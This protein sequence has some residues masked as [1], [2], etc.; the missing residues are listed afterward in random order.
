MARLT[1]INSPEMTHVS[2]AP[3]IPTALAPL[4]MPTLAADLVAL[5]RDL[6]RHPELS[7]QESRTIGALEKALGASGVD[8]VRR[9]LDTALVARIPGRVRGAPVVAVRG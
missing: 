4:F 1:P 9:V 6:H 8:D 5:R 2:D 3:T 7:W